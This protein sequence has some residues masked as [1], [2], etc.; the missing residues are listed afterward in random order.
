MTAHTHDQTPSD[1]RLLLPAEEAAKVLSIS[2]RRLW[3][4]TRTN[5][6]PCVRLRRRDLYSRASLESWIED[7]KNGA[8][9]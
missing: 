5:Q 2:E 1:D 3:M 4:L 7:R 6:V 9:A 8:S